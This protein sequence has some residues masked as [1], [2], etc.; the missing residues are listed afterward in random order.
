MRQNGN[1]N[2]LTFD[3]LRSERE[4][5]DQKSGPE[6]YTEADR[7]NRHAE[8]SASGHNRG[9][10]ESSNSLFDVPRVTND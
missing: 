3:A 1:S 9:K 7:L 2:C 4:L 6:P 10:C 5:Q 8:H